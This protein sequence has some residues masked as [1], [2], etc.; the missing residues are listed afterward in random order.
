MTE[1]T[2]KTPWAGHTGD[3]PLHLD[4]FDGSM[5]E[6]LEL[7]A[8]KYPRNIAFDFMGKPTTY[9]QMIEEIKKCARSLKTIGVRAG[10]KVTI[11][12]PNCPQA[13]YMFY[14]VNLVGGIANMI[15]PLSAEKE[16]EFYLNE[17]ESVTAITLDQFYNKFESI[18]QNTK[19]VNIIIASVK[20]ELS[21]PVRAGYMLTE[22]RK[23]AK[24]PKDAPVLRWNEFLRRGRGYHWTYRVERRAGDEAVI[25]Y[26]GGT[27]GVTKGIL[28]SNR[29][30]NALAAQI[31]ATNP[32][33]HP[34]H[35]MLAI[36][37]MFHGFGLGVSIHSMVA[38]GGHCILIPRFTPQSYAELIKKHKPNLI[39]GVPS[40]FEALLRVKEIEGADLSCL[41]GVFSG[42]DS[43]SI[44]LKKRFDKF[45]HDHG[46]TVSVREG[47]G[48]TE[49]VTASCLTPIHKQKEGSIGIPFPDTYY[50][51]VKP[52]TQEEVPYGEEGE[53]CLT[54]PTMMLEYV[55]HPEETAQTK[56]THADGLTWV[57]TGDLGMMDE[58]GF[59]YFRQRIKRMIVTNGYN[60]YPSQ[61]ENIL[62]GHDYV[63]LSCV[64]GVKDPIKMQ[65]VKAF[66]VLKP[67]YQPTEACKKELLD[68]CRKH[69][70][71]YAMPSDIEF[72]E[73]LPKT[74]VGKVAY[75]VLEEEENAKQAQKAVEDAK[76]AEEDAKR[77]EAAKAEKLSAA[78]KPAAKKPAPK[79][80][81]HPTAKPE[82]AKQ[83]QKADT[84]H[85]GQNN[86]IKE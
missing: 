23:Q 82:P 62:D 7:V 31:V 74:L 33:F 26:S 84:P 67:G 51:I 22:G 19:V 32:F 10:D 41:K 52:G 39:A 28:L 48:T 30:F 37:P 61:L 79:K 71:K 43:L 17:S 14:A 16:I 75:R 54:G 47:Y 4:Y 86:D 80:P 50:K 56:Q 65:R 73:E 66:V 57:H 78:K 81:A 18:R 15:H 27:T 29:N 63:H 6:A 1:I 34:G 20:D 46:A 45:L 38:N 42:G 25:L 44:E 8:K 2:A 21:K 36:M 60:V 58:E 5:F 40:L 69:I 77:A 11:A 59:I 24:I 83:A 12:M 9:P 85:D 72:R 35:K 53:I 64:I 13:I 70:A 68:Y 55:N 76:R 3:V 49:C